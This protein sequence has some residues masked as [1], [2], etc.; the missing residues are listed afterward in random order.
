MPKLAIFSLCMMYKYVC[1][2]WIE[3]MINIDMVLPG[4]KEWT[5]RHVVDNKQVHKVLK[6]VLP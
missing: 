1:M 6:V 5:I 3:G 4:N 2:G